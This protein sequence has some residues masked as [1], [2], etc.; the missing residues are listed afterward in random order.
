MTA[1]QLFE[2]YEN[3]GYKEGRV[4]SSTY[5]N[6]NEAQYLADY[7]DL[8]TA[9]ITAATALNHYLQYGSSEGRTAKNDD[10]TNLTS[11]SN[12]GSTYAL[13]VSGT[14]GSFDN[15]TGTA[16]DDTFVGGPGTTETG[17]IINGGAGTDTL[18]VQFTGAL[19]PAPTV[20]NVENIK[21][22][23]ASSTAAGTFNLAN[24]SGY[25]TLT[26]DNVVSN[27]VTHGFSNISST[28]PVLAITNGAS[29]ATD[30]VTFAYTAAAVA[31]T[32]DAATLNL[33][34][35]GVDDVTIAGI[36][37]LN[38]ASQSSSA[39]T[40]GTLTAAQATT[41]NFSGAGKITVNAGL[42]AAT[43]VN[44]ADLSGGLALS[45]IAAVDGTYTGGSGDDLFNFGANF[46][47]QDKIDG[48]AGTDIIAFSSTVDTSSIALTN[49]ETYMNTGNGV[50]IDVDTNVNGT[51]NNISKFWFAGTGA[52]VLTDA[53]DGTTVYLSGA[54]TSFTAS[55]KSDTAADDISLAL[56]PTGTASLAVTIAA[57]TV[58]SWDTVNINSGAASTVVANTI[59][60]T[61]AT[62]TGTAGS[63]VNVTGNQKLTITNAI[64][65]NNKLSATGLTGA[66]TATFKG[67]TNAVVAEGGTADDSLIGGGAIGGTTVDSLTGGAGKDTLNGHIGADILVGGDGADKFWLGNDLGSVDTISDFVS[68]TDQVYIS[69]EAFGNNSGL[70]TVNGTAISSSDFLSSSA[71]AA[72]STD[73]RFIYDTDN[74]KLYFDADGSGSTYTA[75]QI[76]TLTGAPT[77]A[78]T[79]IIMKSNVVADTFVGSAQ[80]D[81]MVGTTGAD[82]FVG[83]AGLDTIALASGGNDTIVYRTSTDGG[84]TGTNGA[85][86][87]ITGWV[88]AG[89]AIEIDGALQTALD[90]ITTDAAFTWFSANGNPA[91]AEAVNVTTTS[92]AIFVNKAAQT[93]VG[94]ALTTAAALQNLTSVAA[95]LEAQITLT[96]AAAADALVV[97]ECDVAG[98]FGVYLY[99]ET[100]GTADQ[101]DAADLTLLGVVTGDSVTTG[102]FTMV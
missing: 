92:E 68:G 66:L 38:V 39:S 88:A 102:D 93:G 13:T 46:S 60:N 1:L 27:N 71:S 65:T 94:T 52:N 37:T 82:I 15:L 50:T 85:G 97:V 22:S 81:T 43:T 67:N 41:V 44:A 84:T 59:T 26:V 91:D 63:Q 14:T 29:T 8:G 9:G 54:A 11:G 89:E 51:V 25:S 23:Y 96:A 5:A 30:D 34:A 16:N 100:G 3:Y 86:D 57:V 99:V 49:F 55:V 32:A 21:G 77:L 61:I 24:S 64:T 40:I 33:T 76:A 36:E 74:G 87:T 72:S 70:S 28:T 4:P 31:G 35:A 42:A 48:G 79:D 53:A 95:M 98:T 90:D 17:D 7:S 6:F 47:N 69:I 10:G 18:T 2:H 20:T 75:F 78:A 19:T 73:Q 83:A 12:T 58:S 45:G 101:F 80:I 62:L 56:N